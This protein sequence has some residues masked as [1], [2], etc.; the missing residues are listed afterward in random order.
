MF[1]NLWVEKYRPHTL[2][3]LV[4]SDTNRKYFES[5]EDEIPNLLFVGTPGLG[6]TTLA[7]ILIEDILKCQYLYINASDENGIILFAQ[8][9][10]ALVKLSPLLAVLRSSYSMKL[11]A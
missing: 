1:N 6:K 5:I 4:L 7:R 8:R 3:D 9:L 2:S 11:M 10:L